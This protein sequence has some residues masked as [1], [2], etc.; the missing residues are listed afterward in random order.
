MATSKKNVERWLKQLKEHGAVEF[1]GA[2]KRAAII[3]WAQMN[4]ASRH[5][6]AGAT[7]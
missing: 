4:E 3:T 2:T 1:R 5:P 6:L 7:A